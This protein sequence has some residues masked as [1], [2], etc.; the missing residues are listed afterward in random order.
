MRKPDSKKQSDLVNTTFKSQDS[1]PGLSDSSLQ[2]L[3]SLSLL[4]IRA[5]L[6]H[7]LQKW[8]LAESWGCSF[9]LLASGVSLPPPTSTAQGLICFGMTKKRMLLSHGRPSQS[10]SSPGLCLVHQGEE[11]HQYNATPNSPGWPGQHAFTTGS[12]GYCMLWETWL[13][14]TMAQ[15]SVPRPGV[16]NSY[17]RPQVK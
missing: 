14:K 13:I 6:H 1:N 15:A 5:F 10:Y 3:I 2:T 4:S 12:W 8:P 7:P 17:P 11:A 16:I 9:S